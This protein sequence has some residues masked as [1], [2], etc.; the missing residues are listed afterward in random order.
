M[1]TIQELVQREIIYCVSSLVY[2]LTQEGKLDEDLAIDLWSGP[3]DYDAAE[4]ELNQQECRV[5]Q[6]D[7]DGL[8]G[9]YHDGNDEFIV[10][11]YCNSK[12]E[13][14]LE[15][16]NGDLEEYRQEVYEHHLVT[17]Y[18][19]R[20]L[21]EEGQ[22]VVEMFNLHIWCRTCTGMSY[23][24]DPCIVSIYEKLISK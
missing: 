17:P 1:I 10:D 2:T 12:E 22:T 6:D 9:I 20:K 13:A 5:Y 21:V 8:Y 19:G 3:Y 24:Y 14:I 11:T 16:F 15:F 23:I 18:F 7:D 4:Y